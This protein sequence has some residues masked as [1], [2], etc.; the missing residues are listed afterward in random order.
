MLFIGVNFSLEVLCGIILC[1]MWNVREKMLLL[2]RVIG[3]VEIL[4]KVK[5]S[6]KRIF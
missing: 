1:G 3:K 5:L 4:G 6:K 2:K